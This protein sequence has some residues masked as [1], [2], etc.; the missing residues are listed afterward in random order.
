[1]FQLLQEKDWI[2]VQYNHKE[3]HESFDIVKLMS[4]LTGCLNFEMVLFVFFLNPIQPVRRYCYT[5]FISQQNQ[6]ES[7]H[8][9]VRA[10]WQ[11]CNVKEFYIRTLKP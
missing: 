7:S 9:M 10:V 8:N 1:M 5:V 2:E 11:T 4:T 3:N 6:C